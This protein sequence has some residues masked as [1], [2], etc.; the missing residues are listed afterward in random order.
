[1]PESADEMLSRVKLMASGDPQ[2]DLSPNDQAAITYVLKKVEDLEAIAEW[3][4]S[5]RK[6]NT[7]DWMRGLVAQFNGALIRD[8]DPRRCVYNGDY[9]LLR[10]QPS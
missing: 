5:T 3:A 8:G 1:M 9:L 2:W 7:D 10:G 4:L 6:E